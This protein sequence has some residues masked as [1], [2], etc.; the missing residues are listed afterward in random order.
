MPP[1]FCALDQAYGNWGKPKESK[2]EPPVKDNS[3]KTS[4][5]ALNVYNGNEGMG[6][7]RSFCPNCNNCLNANNMLQQKIIEQNIWPRPRWIPQSPH[8]YEPHDPYNRYWMD[9]YSPQRREEFHGGRESFGSGK[10]GSLFNIERF[11]N[12]NNSEGLLQ[13][14]LFILIALFVIQLFEMIFRLSGSD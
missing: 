10:F 9:T 6:D 2:P 3:Q 13:L 8:A 7:V 4:L 1:A 11:G 12:M 14:I 5:S